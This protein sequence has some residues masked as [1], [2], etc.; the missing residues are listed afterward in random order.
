MTSSLAQADKSKGTILLVDDSLTNLAAFSESLADSG[1]QVVVANNGLEALVQLEEYKIDII[2]LDIIMPGIDGFET[3]RRLKTHPDYKHIPVIFMTTLSDTV[4]KVKG[5]SLGAVDYVTKPF[6]KAELL[7]RIRS[8][9]EINQ[10]QSKLRVQN[11]WLVREIEERRKA[12]EELQGRNEALR[13]SESRFRDLVMSLSDWVWELD[14]QFCI[15]YSSD[16]V[17]DLL[18]YAKDEVLGKTPFHFMTLKASN[19]FRAK[20]NQLL[21]SRRPIEEMEH[22][23]IHK[24][25]HSVCLKSNGLPIFDQDNSAVIGYRGASKDVTDLKQIE[26]L[27]VEYDTILEMEVNERTRE[28]EDKN[29]QL[30]QEVQE[31]T[32]AEDALRAS[33][34]RLAMAVHGATYGIWD[35]HP[36]SDE[37]FLSARAKEMI[38]FQGDE[39]EDT[40]SAWR[41]HIHPDDL[42]QVLASVDAYLNRETAF[43]ENIYRMRHKDGH[44][45]W[46]LERGVAVWNGDN[47]P[48]RFSGIYISLNERKET[49]TQLRE[50]E[51]RYNL[52]MQATQDG[53]W[54]WDLATDTVYYS[55]AWRAMLALP[56]T[57]SST[58]PALWQERIHPQ[59]RE[60]ALA[61]IHA[62]LQKSQASYS[63]TYRI[64]TYSGDY[65]MVLDRGQAEWDEQ[66]NCRRFAGSLINVSLLCKDVATPSALS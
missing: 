61:S 14:G 55:S 64:R 63:Q 43:Y 17:K 34:E 66:G 2:L 26:A 13:Q 22:W 35:W 8:H 50:S 32:Q 11:A 1:Y 12:E 16:K 10:L 58:S 25:G 46:I 48:L 42:P 60:Q 7:A 49:Q 15:T 20:L 28:L 4:D 21:E 39:I 65:I 27:S 31:R 40:M 36:A 47:L 29:T 54:D 56:A 52:V 6:Q 38:G 9:V 45:V 3:C 53:I 18:G 33:E 44:E 30:E 19:T 57:E 37:L 23:V 5:L 41:Q 51:Q 24:E 59:D 62:Y